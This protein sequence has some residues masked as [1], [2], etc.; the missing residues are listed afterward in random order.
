MVNLDIMSI[1]KPEIELADALAGIGN[2]FRGRLLKS[3]NGLKT[4]FAEGN[5]DAC[6]LRA[7]R[8]CEVLLRWAQ[9][10]LTGKYTPFGTQISN[11][12]AE[13]EALEQKPK[14]AGHE[15]IRI[16]IPR[17]VSFLYTFRNKRGIGHEGGDV[18]AN[19]IDA[20]T[21]VRIADWCICELIRLQYPIS[22]EEAQAM[23]DGVA[24]RQLPQIW[25]ILGKKRVLT[26]G[27]R[28]REQTLLLLY[29]SHD[30]AV[31]A[32]DL[33]EWIEHSNQASYRKNV[34][35]KMHKDRLIEYDQENQMVTISPLGISK[36]E[37]ELLGSKK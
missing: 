28:Y 34:L 2:T 20:A 4:A 1:P 23:C 31:P 24:E 16:L 9:V 12:K 22:L 10:E 32:E 15:S 27:L 13:C 5:F 18:D 25:E 37:N 8:F 7:G 36:V 3:Y 21:V 19:K 33:F 14:T 17:A 11:F 29:S 26:K 6:G 35:K 30:S